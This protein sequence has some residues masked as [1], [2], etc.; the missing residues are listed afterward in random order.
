MK[1]VKDDTSLTEKLKILFKKQEV[2]IALIVTA[3]DLLIST[4]VLAVTETVAVGA[5]GG[6]G[7]GFVQK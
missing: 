1:M 5:A 6:G 2:T 4:I 7:S 3:V